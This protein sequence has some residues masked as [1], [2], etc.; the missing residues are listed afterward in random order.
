MS[1][2]LPPKLVFT[3]ALISLLVT[4]LGL[5][6]SSQAEV[7]RWVDDKGQVHFGDRRAA[8]AGFERMDAPEEDAT[9]DGWSFAFTPEAD[10]VL[11]SN[12]EGTQGKSTLLSSGHWT[13]SGAAYEVSSLVRFDIS[14]LLQELN[15]N[16]D[17]RIG[18]ARLM[19]FANT[20]TRLYGQGVANKEPAGHSTLRGDNAFYVKPAHNNWQEDTVTWKGF[21]DSSHY[22]P[23]FI[24][25]L[26][27]ITVPG[28]GSDHSRNYEIDMK[29]L[30]EALAQGNMR[31]FTLELRPQ[32]RSSG[33]QVTFFSREGGPETTPKLVIELTQREGINSGVAH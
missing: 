11:H 31:E 6:A 5:N 2:R 10:A 32:R 12:K 16:P 25:N 21:Y 33:A 8:G 7:Y 30:V 22:T 23:S 1:D 3:Y 24:R 9:N 14:A 17:K 18:A 27:A 26:P 19:L 28:S 4:A 15:S 29:V 20:E 13:L